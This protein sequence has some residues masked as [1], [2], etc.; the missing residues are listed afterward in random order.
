MTANNVTGDSSV[1]SSDVESEKTGNCTETRLQE[2]KP[3]QLIEMFSI[4][5]KTK[6]LE[7]PSDDSKTHSPASLV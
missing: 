7:T 1:N 5:D 4:A 6:G 2:K 3:D